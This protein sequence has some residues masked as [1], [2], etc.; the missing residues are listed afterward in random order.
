M[1][2]GTVT[3]TKTRGAL[4][5]LLIFVAGLLSGLLATNRYGVVASDA[6]DVPA[7]VMWDNWTGRSW[8]R[9]AGTTQ[10]PDRQFN[11]YR[12]DP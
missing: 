12:L 3:I 1:N 8:F 7:F 11:W 10:G 9:Y 6:G 4:F 2:D 5:G